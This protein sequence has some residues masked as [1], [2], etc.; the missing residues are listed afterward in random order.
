MM[1]LHEFIQWEANHNPSFTK[2]KFRVLSA[3]FFTHYLLMVAEDAFMDVTLK[4][5]LQAGSASRSTLEGLNEDGKAIYI[6]FWFHFMRTLLFG[7]HVTDYYIRG[8]IPDHRWRSIEILL[9]HGADPNLSIQWVSEKPAILF[10]GPGNFCHVQSRYSGAMK[11]EA[12]AFL[13]SYGGTC[14]L[15]DL[16]L[17]HSPSNA[18]EILRYIDGFN[19]RGK[20]H[21]TKD[22]ESN[23]LLEISEFNDAAPIIGQTTHRDLSP[24]QWF[25]GALVGVLGRFMF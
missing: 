9:K 22:L 10:T 16:L 5:L 6:S 4:S 2:H 12:E 1:G 18:N 8:C 13:K 17:F 7:L 21:N 15:R 25:Q 23:G 24:Y 14:S 11:P 20:A 19:T 3:I